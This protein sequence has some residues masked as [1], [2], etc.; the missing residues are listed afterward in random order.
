MHAEIQ[1]G[2]K[3]GSQKSLFWRTVFFRTKM[4]LSKIRSPLT[5][6]VLTESDN[7]I[8]GVNSNSS[9]SD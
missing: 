2:W 5:N 4:K 8:A 1:R 9:L 3:S 6:S 7:F